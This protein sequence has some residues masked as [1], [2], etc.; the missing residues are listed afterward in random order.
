MIS[1]IWLYIIDDTKELEYKT[2]YT[3]K[4]STVFIK[5]ILL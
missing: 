1:K 5:H 3:F 4:S 2:F